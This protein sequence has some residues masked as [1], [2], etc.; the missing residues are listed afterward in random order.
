MT[1]YAI[2]TVFVFS[3]LFFLGCSGNNTAITPQ[4]PNLSTQ[5]ATQQN[6][7]IWGAF[8][9]A[10]NPET[11]NAEIVWR[12]DLEMHLN[13]TGFVTPPKCSDCIKIT[14]S[15]Y[16]PGYATWWVELL[17][18]NPTKK[19]GYDVRACLTNLG[20]KILVNP[21]GVTQIWGMPMPFKVIGKLDDR[22]FPPKTTVGQSFKFYFPG[23]TTWENVSF[24]IDTSWPSYVDEPLVEE[25]ASEK[26]LN[27]GVA[28]TWLSIKIWD[29][30]NDLDPE[31]IIADL[32]GIGGSPMTP[33]FDDGQHH[34]GAAGDGV[35]GITD[36]RVKT[37]Y[38]AGQYMINVFAPDMGQHFGW[39]QI[40]LTVEQ[41]TQAMEPVIDN[42]E[43][44]HTTAK[45]PEK[46]QITVNAHNPGGGPLTY[47]FEASSGNFSG[48]SNNVVYW[49][50][51]VSNTGPQT[52]TAQVVN[53]QG[54]AASVDITLWSTDLDIVPG[55]TQGKIP[56]G[57]LES[58]IPEGSVDMQ[59]DYASKVL[60]T[61]YW[62]TW[63][64]YCVQEMP[65]LDAM[66][67]K[68]KANPDYAHVLIDIGEDGPK[69]QNFATSNGYG[70]TNWLLD[71]GTYFDVWHDFNGGSGGIPQHA[72]FD[73][74]GDCRWSHIGGLASVGTGELEAAIDQLL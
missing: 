5:F 34:D 30:Q 21:D 15:L 18:K 7:Q 42:Y 23:D 8:D 61:N 17:F 20:K 54:G 66:Y 70:A 31:N 13:V 72:L 16:Q 38:P 52:I 19:T 32:G 53:A 60:Y 11:Q 29:H 55:S 46:I 9:V 37:M 69:V 47:N 74:D 57:T 48:Q 41:S 63:C 27:N 62:A 49:T 44:D 58:I 73:R 64:G 6:H 22:T 14:G 39:G 28:T 51:S 12:R 71:P 36:V 40:P 4:N 65:D 59:A 3:V 43:I 56:P 68:Y 24:L 25:G 50:P 67:N 10:F 33:M 45:A 1:R 2:L 35:Y 26:V